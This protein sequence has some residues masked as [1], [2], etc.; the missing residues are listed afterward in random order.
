[1]SSPIRLGCHSC[2][3]ED[4]DGISELP[5]D[6]LDISVVQ[7]L[8]ESRQEVDWSDRSRSPLEW[9]THLGICPDC[10]AEDK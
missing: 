5:P 9:Y 8:E 3:R 4:F 7:T 1:V 2:D 10:Q 6:W